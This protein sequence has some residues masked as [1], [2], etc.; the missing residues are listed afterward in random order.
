[1]IP[2][3]L[4]TF[5]LALSLF[6]VPLAA[7][8]FDWKNYTNKETVTSL[9]SFAGY[10]WAA[11]T[12]G[13]VRLDPDNDSVLTYMNSDGLGST[14]INFAAP[15]GD[16]IAYFGSTD[17]VLS[18]LR[19]K[20]G[21]FT[22]AKLQGREGTTISLNSAVVAG[23]FLW[24]ASS[25]GIIKYDLIRHGGEVKET[26][27]NLGDFPAETAVRD[28]VVSGG[29]IIAVTAAGLAIADAASEFLLDPNE[30]TTVSAVVNLNCVAVYDDVY[31]GANTGLYQLLPGPVLQSVGLANA[32]VLDLTTASGNTELFA[33][34]NRSGSRGILAYTADQELPLT[35]NADALKNM[36]ALTSNRGLFVGTSGS[37]IYGITNN[38]LQSIEVPGPAANDL[39][40]GGYSSAG[41]LHVIARDGT[42]STLSDGDWK[43]QSITT[44]EQLA[45]IVDR[46]DNVWICTFGGGVYRLN[47]ANELAN[48]TYSNSPLIG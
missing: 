29:R 5:I 18:R 20:T 19:I 17:G 36:T 10:V 32:A 46:D 43:R 11:T 6:S 24:I 31:V 45:G 21:E 38:E 3:K 41:L 4:I 35:G 40:G 2:G 1:M 42:L 37:G 14:L 12:G 7:Q 25:V 33:L 23:D 27:R 15:L 26:Y 22:F 44:K 30:W 9:A 48:F 13:V 34:F 39:V 47:A 8:Q 28:L 16:S